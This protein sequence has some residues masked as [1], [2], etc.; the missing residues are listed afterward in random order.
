MTDRTTSDRGADGYRRTP[1]AGPVVRTD[2]IEVYL[3]QGA[4][5]S[6]L[7]VLQLRRATAPMVGDWH[8]VMGHIEPGEAA[9]ECARRE[10]GEEVGLGAGDPAWVGFWQLE[11]VHPYYLAAVEAVVLSPRFAVEVRPG[12]EPT[13]NHEHDGSRWISEESVEVEFVW[14]GQRAALR[15]IIAEMAQR[16]TTAERLRLD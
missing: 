7:A 14:P 9:V 2:I 1:G 4:P 11:Q 13:L 16:T 15:E 8:P 6:G 10:L 5:G 3:F 12:W